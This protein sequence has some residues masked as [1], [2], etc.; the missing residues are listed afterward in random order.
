[1]NTHVPGQTAPKILLDDAALA[2][3]L[4]RIAHELI[5]RNAE[6]GDLALVGIHTR[7][8]PIAERLRRTRRR[9]VGRLGRHGRRRHHVP[10]R[11]RSR[12]GRRLSTPCPASRPGHRARF[13][14]RGKDG[15]ARR[16]R[17]L[18]R[19]HDSGGDRR[20]PRV[21][22]SRARPAGRPDRPRP[23]RA[24]DPPRLRRARTFPPRAASGSVSSWARSTGMIASCSPGGDE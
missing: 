10:P 22:P 6:L 4:S 1:M 11:R 24:P 5:E 20:P 14:A 16:R 17:A 15:R 21:R 3:T 12:A 19:P 2:R 9:A 23:S 7:G 13:R 8:V 18:H